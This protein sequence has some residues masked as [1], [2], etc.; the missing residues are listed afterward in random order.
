MAMNPSNPGVAAAPKPYY[1]VALFFHPRNADAAERLTSRL[2]AERAPGGLP[3]Y[4]A[5]ANAYAFSGIGDVD[6]GTGILCLDVD[7]GKDKQAEIL[8]AHSEAALKDLEVHYVKSADGAFDFVQSG[9]TNATAAAET[10]QASIP[11]GAVAVSENPNPTGDGP[12]P[13]TELLRG[14]RRGSSTPAGGTA[15]GQP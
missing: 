13:G 15:G 9:A 7:V 5:K 2:S 8:A 11:Q 12:R 14:R 3:Y 1:T 6:H 4:C 10:P